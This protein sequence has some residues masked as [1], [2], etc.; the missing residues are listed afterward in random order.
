MIETER[1]TLRLPRPDDAESLVEAISDPEV[2]RYIG[3]GSTG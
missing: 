2:M 1:L 3:D